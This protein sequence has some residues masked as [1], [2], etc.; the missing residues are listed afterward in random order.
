MRR[1]CPTIHELLTFDA[2]ARLESVT[3]AANE[4]CISVSGVSKQIAGLEAFIG[5][6]LLE[7]SGRG[8]KLTATG[9]EYWTKI[10]PCLQSLEVA[11]IEA[12]EGRSRSGMLVVSCVPTFLTNWLIPRLSTF[13][14]IYPTAMFVFTQHIELGD[15]FPDDVDAVLSHGLGGWENITSD[16]ITGREFICAYS[17]D[18]TGNGRSIATVDDLLSHALLRVDDAAFGWDN[19]L[20]HH[21]IDRTK[22]HVGPFFPQYF[23]L[24][25][26]AVSGLGVALIPRIL[27]E[28]NLK[29]GTLAAFGGVVNN[30]QGHYLCYRAE[31]RLRPVLAA[32]RA[33]LLEQGR[34]ESANFTGT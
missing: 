23:S 27:V 12:R 33:W 17:P 32:F 11:T 34:S 9:R 19:W 7:K 1:T 22:A 15:P 13:R 21:R 30:E 18:L 28:K 31:R 25:Q 16:Y 2:A 29:D 10:S 20:T 24:I 3:K 6:P 14:N 8:V 26:A 5:Q 4:M